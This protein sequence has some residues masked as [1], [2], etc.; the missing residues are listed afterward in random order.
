MGKQVLRNCKLW[1]DGYDLSG[2]MNALALN[3]GANMLDDSAF[4][5]DTK[6]STGGIKTVTV[7][8][9]GY[10]EGAPDEVLQARIG[11]QDKPMTMCAQDG[12]AGDVAYFFPATLSEYSPGGAH[13][14][15]FAFS[16]SG[17]ASGDLVRGEILINASSISA[18]GNSSGAELGAVTSAQEL[19]AAL[20]V[21]SAS[22]TTPTLDVVVE[23]DVDNT[24]GTATPQITFAQATDVTSEIA[25]TAGAITDTWYRIAYTVSG[26]FDFVVAVGIK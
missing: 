10:W 17:E 26:T 15:L 22:G 9:E 6:S 5:D 18:S 2:Y 7:Q 14:E 23:S 11:V 19:V 1:M 8:H 4:G 25:S 16:V 24:F 21:L 20:H 3:Y 12:N 13:G